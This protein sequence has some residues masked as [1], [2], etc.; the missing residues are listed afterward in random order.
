MTNTLLVTGASG[1][2]GANLVMTARATGWH[3]VPV[4]HQHPLRGGVTLDLTDFAATQALVQQVRPQWVVHCAAAA[5]V[6]WCEDHPAEA[7]RVNVEASAVLAAA[8]KQV[9]AGLIHLSTD[10][11]FYGEDLA[12]R[13]HEDDTPNPPSVYGQTKWQA[14]QAVLNL[15]PS[16]LVLRVNFYG[17]NFQPKY[18]LAEWMLSKLERGERLPGFTDVTFCPMLANDLC[19]VML[20]LIAQCEQAKRNHAPVPNGI[21]HAVGGQALSKFDFAHAIARTFGLDAGL[22]DATSFKDVALRA[23]RSPNLALA[24]G[25]I[26]HV[27][28]HAMPDVDSGLSKFKQLREGDFVKHLKGL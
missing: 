5:N 20:A 11:V 18:S 22:I 9:G 10:A 14:E 23:P 24:V 27:L 16:A 2:L 4:T 15:L 21:F 1:L 6:D 28:G 26:Q 12:K 8:A 17:W 3:V 25:K 19:E 13:Y 7:Q